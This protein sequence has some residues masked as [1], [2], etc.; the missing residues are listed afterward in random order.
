MAHF[1]ETDCRLNDDYSDEYS[2][3][4]NANET[5]KYPNRSELIFL[6]AEKHC[7]RL[8]L[9]TVL[10]PLTHTYLAVATTLNHLVGCNSIIENEFV[11][12]CIDE[13]TNRVEHGDCKYGESISTDSIRNCIKL[14]EKWSIIDISTRTGAR[15]LSLNPVYDSPIGI[16]HTIDRIS[17]FIQI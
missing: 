3:D 5:K 14:F 11:K 7:D 1:L 4:E 12:K 8:V 6:P 17:K 13:I 10:A 16:T 15:L 9:M 2:D